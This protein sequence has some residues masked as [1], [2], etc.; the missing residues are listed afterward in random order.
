MSIEP[1]R[2]SDQ[3]AP[4]AAFDDDSWPCAALATT[5]GAPTP[6][7]LDFS[8]IEEPWREVLKWLAHCWINKPTPTTLRDAPRT[9]RVTFP[10]PATIRLRFGAARSLTDWL[11]GQG[12]MDPQDIDEDHVIDL[13]TDLR[14]QGRSPEYISDQINILLSWQAFESE[15][16]SAFRLPTGLEIERVRL[17]SRSG[18]NQTRRIRE[19]T[20]APLMWWCE[21]FIDDFAD[22]V[23]QL[24]ERASTPLSPPTTSESKAAR[25]RQFLLDLME[26]RGGL[27]VRSLEFNDRAVSYLAWLSG[28]D[29]DTLKA[30]LGA[31]DLKSDKPSDDCPVTLP[32]KTLDDHLAPFA[33]YYDLTEYR[34]NTWPRV[35]RMLQT[36]SIVC[37]TYL[38]GMRPEEVRRL[39]PGCISEAQLPEGGIRYL[40]HGTVTKLE[41]EADGIAAGSRVE[42]DAAWATIALAARALDV[43][44]RLRNQ[45]SPESPWLFPSVETG[46]M[47]SAGRAATNINEF[48][49][50]V[51]Q[52]CSSLQGSAPSIPL[53]T[54]GPL[55]LRRFRRTLA[56]H[57]RNQ[58]QGDVTLGVQYQH[59]GTVIGGGYASV[60]STGWS[61][62]LDQ[63][64]RETR[65]KVIQHLSE[66]LLD[67]A[68]ISGPAAARASAAAQEFVTEGV[69][70][71]EGSDLRTLL[72]APGMQ[73]FDNRASLTLCVFDPDRALCERVTG[74]GSTGSPN[75]IGCIK[76]CTNRAMTDEHAEAL[77]Q[78][79]ARKRQQAAISPTPLQR[80][81]EQAAAELEEQAAKHERERVIPT[82]PVH[83][84]M[85]HDE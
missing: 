54:H 62:L 35:A 21:R 74:Q 61:E 14:A 16:P 77:R 45:F 55:S 42:I 83:E 64:G 43:A 51:N 66:Q 6:A 57:I 29:N 53:D 49:D 70:F 73:I 39:R 36:A 23:L 79:A 9:R 38:T 37:V 12:V 50:V 20:I 59:V 41:R 3:S 4:I 2:V 46:E 84:E 10:A 63:E 58:P 11:R 33:Q 27:P 1:H 69:A 32:G 85:T 81:L 25:A 56:W 8:G 18:E 82:V 40:I 65:R 19:K 44:E 30:T 26:E 76:G 71:M 72:S 22:D 24:L 13:I 78:E 48:V 67:G 47:I 28:L 34:L 7:T 68:G 60:A 52:R 5:A 15:L 17:R 75:L 31:L 80:R